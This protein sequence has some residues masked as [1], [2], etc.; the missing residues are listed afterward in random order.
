MVEQRLAAEMIVGSA[1]SEEESA[2][3]SR[4]PTKRV[5]WIVVV[6]ATITCLVAAVILL[7]LIITADVSMDSPPLAPTSAG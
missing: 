7:F 1:E 6:L 3:V 4:L 2:P 5:L